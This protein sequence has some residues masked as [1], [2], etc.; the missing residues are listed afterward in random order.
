MSDGLSWIRHIDD[1]SAEV[2]FG[3]FLSRSPSNLHGLSAGTISRGVFTPNGSVARHFFMEQQKETTDNAVHVYF[4]QAENGGPI[5]I[6]SA[7]NV[8]TRIDSI[9]TAHP[10]RLVVRK[11]LIGAG[12]STEM[13]LH[14]RFSSSRLIGE[15]FDVTQ[16]LEDFINAT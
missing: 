13:E 6:G 5:K 9:Q 1:Y 7:Q 3:F 10:Y 2:S 8:K 16:E 12:K 11:V 14:K 4:I 15:W